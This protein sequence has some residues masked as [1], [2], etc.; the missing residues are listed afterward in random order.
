MQKFV[1]ITGSLPILEREA[2]Y[3]NASA[4]IF[5]GAYNTSKANIALA[6][7]YNLPLILSDIPAFAIYENATKIHPNHLENLSD[8]LLGSEKNEKNLQKN[9]FEDMELEKAIF[10]KYKILL[11]ENKKLAKK[12]LMK[13]F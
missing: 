11:S 4:W 12:T 1:H 8:L 10:E 3:K 5:V 7:S 6:K 13:F 2:L 9:D